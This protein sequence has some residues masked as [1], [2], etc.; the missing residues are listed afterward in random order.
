MNARPDFTWRNSLPAVSW[1]TILLVGMLFAGPLAAQTPFAL[2]NIGQK[3]DTEDARMVGRGGW[4]MAVHDSTNPGL[5]NIAGLSALRQVAVSFIGYGTSTQSE[6]PNSER[7]VNRVV[8]PDFRLAVPV[9]KGRL[10]LSTGF[11]MDRSFRYDT[12]SPFTDYARGDT[13]SG[14]E[15]FLR[16]GTLFGVPIG[17]AWE[18]VPGLSL[19]A[20]VSLVR[21]NVTESMYEIF[22]EPINVA[23]SPFYKTVLQLQKDTFMG[24]SYTWSALYKLGERARVGASWTPAYEV[25]ADRSIS[26]S[27][28]SQRY[29][30][31]WSMTMPD[32]YMVGAQANLHGRWWLGG[33]YQIQT[34]G[35][36][37]GPQEWLGEGME[38]E[39]TISVGVEKR[40]AYQRH[41]GLD[42]WPLRMG[43]R[44]R[45]WAYQVG[46]NP[47]RE[48]TYSI[49]TGFPFRGKLGVLDLALSYSTIGDLEE[50]GL[51]DSI[52]KMSLSVTGLENWW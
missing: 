40:I 3:A 29:F 7:T 6:D 14:V 15:H 35:E 41:G 38:D 12:I 39:T 20:T 23:G 48:N 8:A 2:T 22:L 52:W 34:F 17:V 5:K 43:F 32:E 33:D 19:G 24:T 4:G 18:A 9:V 13:L 45:Q 27:G 26:L 25:D 11:S 36:F 51:E 50:N 21:G 42:N 37:E 49:G 47:V 44:T 10:A 30:T 46:G 16:Q 31:S 28:L 1:L